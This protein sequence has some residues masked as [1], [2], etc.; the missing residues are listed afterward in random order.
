M[1][2]KLRELP[3]TCLKFG[4]IKK[5]AIASFQRI[6]L[7]FVGSSLQTLKINFTK[8]QGTGNDFILVNNFDGSLK[9]STEQIKALCNR[10]FG[11]GSDGLI[12]IEPSDKAQF[13]VNFYNPDGSVS[14]CGNGSRCAV[15]FAHAENI[16][17]AVANFDAV[18]G[19][20]AGSVSVNDVEISMRDV[21][22]IEERENGLYLQTGSPH[23]IVL[24]DDVEKVD[25]LPMA[26]NIRYSAKYKEQGI[27]V[28]VVHQISD[29]QIH[30]RT[31]ERGV[32]DETLS[33]GTG[34]TAAALSIAL[35]NDHLHEVHVNTRGGKL[36]VRFDHTGEGG[37]EGI[38]LKGP[39]A[40]V[41]TGEVEI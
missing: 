5:C 10:K 12:L 2:R 36:S 25:L 28:N 20:H 22:E 40:S 29:D 23:L 21:R 41:F 32:E 26:R 1:G 9:L 34:V 38:W 37:F 31:Y 4:V 8:Y 24:V 14:F 6:D 39:V 15:H 33:C 13:Y 3:R 19:I 7:N 30:M 35:E 18:D 27:N 17:G 16:C 11:I